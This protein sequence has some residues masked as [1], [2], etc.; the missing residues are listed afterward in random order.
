MIARLLPPLLLAVSLP[1]WAEG[2]CKTL[3]HRFDAATL[4]ALALEVHVGELSVAPSEDAAVHLSLEVCPRND[5]LRRSK[6]ESAELRVEQE[7]ERLA[8]RVSE[9]RFEEHWTLRVPPGVALGVEMGIGEARITG[10]RGDIA[11][12]LGIGELGIE[13]LAADYGKVSAETGIGDA[14]IEVPDDAAESGRAIV[15]A[16]SGWS[17]TGK[18]NIT[19][20]VGIGEADLRLR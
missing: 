2:R 10:M 18:G 5:W 13:G 7:G 17:S 8:L 1:A 14:T 9:D 3:E 19:A 12:E 15:S 20:E 6:A 11:V 16:H 4:K